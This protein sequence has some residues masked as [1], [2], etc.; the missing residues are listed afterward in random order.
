MQQGAANPMAVHVLIVNT[1]SAP[2][3]SIVEGAET[4]HV[5]AMNAVF[6]IRYHDSWIMVDAAADANLLRG[7]GFSQAAFDS[8]ML[9][10]RGARI[11][12]LTHE[13]YDHAAGVFQSADSLLLARKTLLT[14]EQLQTFSTAPNDPQIRIDSMR[15][16][17]YNAYSYGTISRIAPGVALIKAPGHTPG[18]QMVYVR[19]ASGAEVILAGDVAWMMAGVREQRQK[20]LAVSRNAAMLGVAENRN[21]IAAQLRWL[22]Q[23]SNEGVHVVIAHD[24]AELEKLIAAGVL[25][26]GLALR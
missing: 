18:S 2:L 7:K 17:R 14:P 10:L 6:Q 9:G 5:K 25:M 24:L 1:F 3:S 21:Q 20:P 15:A 22:Q 12:V 26:P 8:A 23:A 19:L 4:R 13:H 11:I 16:A